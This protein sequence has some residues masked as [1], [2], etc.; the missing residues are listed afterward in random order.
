MNTIKIILKESG[1]VAE[2]KIDFRMYKNAYQNKLIDIF[3]PKSILYS[4][5]NNTFINA[6]KSG[7]LLIAPNGTQI[8]TNS[9]YADYKTDIDINGVIYAVYE[10][11]MPKEYSVYAGTTT[12]VVNVVNVD[13]TDVENPRILDVITTQE[14]ELQILNS[15]YLDQEEPIEPSQFEI[16]EGRVDNIEEQVED[17]EV[18]VNINTENIETNTQGLA[19][20]DQ[21]ITDLENKAITGFEYIGRMIGNQM[22]TNEQLDQFVRESTTPSREKKNGD[23]I[24]FILQIPDETDK[25]YRY[26]YGANG[27]S[28]VEI[29]PE[30]LATNSAHGL[31]KGTYNEDED[32]DTQVNIIGGEIE[33]IFVKDNAENKRDIK[34]FLNTLDNSIEEIIDGDKI[35]GV[36]EKAIADKNGND[37]AE[38]YMTINSGATKQDIVKYALPRTFNDTYYISSE[39]YTKDIPESET[40]VQFSIQTASV[41]TFVLFQLD[42][43]INADFELSSKNSSSNDIFVSAD[44]NCDVYFRLSTEVKQ[45]GKAWETACVEL[46]TRHYLPANEIYKIRFGKDFTG[47]INKVLKLTNNDIIRQRLEVVTEESA[48]TTFKVYSNEIYPSTFNLNTQIIKVAQGFMGEQEVVVANGE[49]ND[50]II[51]FRVPT[52]YSLK[53]SSEIQL[54][55]IYEGNYTP[56]TEIVVKLDTGNIRLVTPY[57]MASGNATI[58]DL[59]QV[60]KEVGIDKT[61]WIFKGFV[62]I[63]G[64]ETIIRVDEDYIVKTIIS[65]EAPTSETVG[66]IGQLYLNT[67]TSELFVLDEIDTEGNYIWVTVDN[68]MKQYILTYN[69][70]NIQH[71]AENVN[72]ETIRNACLNAK[73]FVYMTYSNLL[74]IP[75][76]ITADA[77]EFA[78][79]YISGNYQRTQRI[80]INSQNIIKVD[81]IISENTNNKLQD[82]WD[83]DE[84]QGLDTYFCAKAIMDNFATTEQVQQ[85]IDTAVVSAI[86]EDY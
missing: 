31:I 86:N 3:V 20:A 48:L 37:I 1:S 55:L 76:F 36:A 26:T 34:E 29:P 79:N 27:W 78:S 57:N 19:D 33:N 81:N 64:S 17:L 51:E 56:D 52:Y 62:D 5:D 82:Y 49:L 43:V 23:Q 42:N 13:N 4:N 53:S 16:L 32:K 41:G 12:I 68:G 47:L 18:Q 2:L 9:Y 66:E 45:E 54:K 25:N 83:Y 67:T 28:Y 6:V 75:V 7:A 63:Q 50:N 84:E 38:T 85:M 15:E 24:T 72:Y 70:T 35:V 46:T 69:G 77:V 71:N 59:E 8:K 21:R 44:R 73:Y 61:T 14:V 60:A 22:P 65:N 80:I 58:R 11:K 39:G 30:Q 10:Q 74:Y 40:G